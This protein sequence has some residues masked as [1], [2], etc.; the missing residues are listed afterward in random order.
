ME[1]LVVDQLAQSR[2]HHRPSASIAR[3]RHNTPPFVR[4][5]HVIEHWQVDVFVVGLAVSFQ[6]KLLRSNA[7][8]LC[9]VL[10]AAYGRNYYKSRYLEWIRLQEASEAEWNPVRIRASRRS[11][12]GDRRYS[13]ALLFIMTSFNSSNHIKMIMISKQRIQ[14][15]KLDAIARRW[16]REQLRL[17]SRRTITLN[18]RQ[19]S[20]TER[21]MWVYNPA[22]HLL[23]WSG[24][25]QRCVRKETPGAGR[26]ANGKQRL[27]D[28][29]CC[30]GD[31]KVCDPSCCF[32]DPEETCKL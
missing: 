25:G 14:N 9:W 18:T 6:G 4:W 11:S 17:T 2:H 19:F 27:I 8:F 3:W 30:S 1:E 24:Q 26:S 29:D 10:S 7:K 21:W 13:A 12:K 15:F 31:F 16:V 32:D 20:D 23:R 28:P 5:R 22:Y